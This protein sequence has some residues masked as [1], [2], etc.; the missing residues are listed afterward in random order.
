MDRARSTVLALSLIAAA[1][2]LA[3]LQVSRVMVADPPQRV[4]ERDVKF[5]FQTGKPGEAS[6][7]RETRAPQRAHERS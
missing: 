4:E 7:R 5:R 6:D 2:M 3:I 1:L